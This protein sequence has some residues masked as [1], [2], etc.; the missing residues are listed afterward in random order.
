M[1]EQV[2]QIARDISIIWLALLVIIV[3]A[4]LGYGAIKLLQATRAT[5]SKISG[6]LHKAGRKVVEVSDSANGVA[7]QVNYRTAAIRAVPHGVWSG[8]CAF[9]RGAK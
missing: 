4:A 6:A 9:L 5:N 3:L 2:L 8:V 1:N 7:D